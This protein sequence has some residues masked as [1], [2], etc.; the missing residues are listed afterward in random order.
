MYPIR[1]NKMYLHVSTS[2]S[3]TCI[4]NLRIFHH[5]RMYHVLAQLHGF[6][7]CAG[8]LFNYT[9][10]HTSH[11]CRCEHMF[12]RLCRLTS[13][14]SFD[15]T[16]LCWLDE[17]HFQNDEF[18]TQGARF[19]GMCVLR[20]SFPHNPTPISRELRSGFETICTVI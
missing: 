17:G 14:T 11:R 18:E 12:V 15:T 9:H 6:R 13:G 4:Q 1:R 7:I 8:V 19:V 10:C 2:A 20:L 5:V 3:S 16:I